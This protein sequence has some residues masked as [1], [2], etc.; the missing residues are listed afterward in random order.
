MNN[1]CSNP[2]P[3]NIHIKQVKL[4]FKLW[5]HRINVHILALYLNE[6]RTGCP[7]YNLLVL[8]IIDNYYFEKL[9]KN[10]GDVTYRA[11][12]NHW[13]FIGFEVSDISLYYLCRGWEMGIMPRMRDRN[14]EV[15]DLHFLRNEIKYCKCNF[16]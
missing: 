13:Y 10:F 14:I 11:H 9:T 3:E 15:E 5:F 16:S 12:R 8:L 7:K 1:L 2:D 4:N 6:W